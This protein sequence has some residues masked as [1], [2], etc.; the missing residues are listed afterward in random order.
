MKKE[1]LKYKIVYY[2]FMVGALHNFIGRGSSGVTIIPV[3]IIYFALSGIFSILMGYSPLNPPGLLVIF[4][5]MLC[6]MPWVILSNLI[7]K[8]A[9]EIQIKFKKV[10]NISDNYSFYKG[11]NRFVI[12]LGFITVATCNIAILF[13]ILFLFSTYLIRI[14]SNFT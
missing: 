6:I 1:N 14:L 10:A 3:A 7:H 12:F 8:K 9:S 5:L 2:Q 11:G 13:Y 4:S